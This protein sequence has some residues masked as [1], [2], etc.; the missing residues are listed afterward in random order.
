MSI[1][2]KTLVIIGVT[3]LTLIAV[4]QIFSKITFENQLSGYE[5]YSLV[6][7]LT[8]SQGI[9][10]NEI[11]TFG[12]IA[13]D[14]ALRTD[15]YNFMKTGNQRY[16]ES[17]LRNENLL[18]QRINL[19]I[20]VNSN[21][22]TIWNK[23][24][25]FDHNKDFEDQELIDL[26][27]N[28]DFLTDPIKNRGSASGVINVKGRAMMLVSRSVK[29]PADKN[30]IVGSL[31]LGRYLTDEEISRIK[32]LLKLKVTFHNYNEEQ[33]LA[34][35][36]YQHFNGKNILT[37][38]ID[39][40]TIAGYVVFRD[41]Y[42]APAFL[43]R[44]ET[45]RGIFE[46][47]KVFINYFMFALTVVVILITLL[48]ISLMIK[49]VS[50]RIQ[51]LSSSVLKIGE[52][53]DVS[54]RVEEQ[55]RDEIQ[56]L[57]SEINKMLYQL[58][59]S[60]EKRKQYERDLLTAKEKAEKSDKLKS[61]FLAQMSHEIRTP[62]NAILSHISLLQIEFDESVPKEL[63]TSIG[64]IN[65]GGQRLIRTM[66]LIMNVSMIRSGAYEAKKE[67]IL[68]FNEVVM[69]VCQEYKHLAEEKNISFVCDKKIADDKK[70]HA[71]SYALNQILSNLL[72]NAVNYTEK[73]SIICETG[74]D[75]NKRLYIEISDTGIGMS[76]EYQEKMFIPFTQE[77]E[78]YTR[79]Y[80]GNGLG[81]ALVKK[82]C[83]INDIEI[84]VTSQKNLGT[85]FT[86][87]F[88]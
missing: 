87:I 80:E 31:I 71:D 57:A 38:P 1:K 62:L 8:R 15:T 42:G 27:V 74:E 28:T 47:G 10:L 36:N 16:I 33:I 52:A 70:I 20:F 75:E 49:F 72:D 23:I 67:D 25:N 54:L 48:L 83:E 21:K 56:Y 11:E 34:E 40:S 30:D 2:L 19:A 41:I 3:S 5:D 59:I 85:K 7:T 64:L 58:E 79:K 86:L 55:G 84:K 66:D 29:N 51:S 9:L 14:W 50:G 43:L 68:L 81:L 26:L 69:P 17:N 32:N 65:R 13:S 76:K 45:E 37:R 35:L 44:V 22:K 63:E 24:F 6:Q 78:G 77:D 12:N 82:Y 60:L 18:G 61:E 53:K 4:L 73:G 88:T 46:R 39:E